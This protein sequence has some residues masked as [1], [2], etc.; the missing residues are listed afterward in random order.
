[1]AAGREY[2]KH[3]QKIIDRYYEHF[4]TIKLT[5]LSEAVTE[6]YLADTP[7]KQERLWKTVATALAKLAKD[8]DRVAKILEEKNVEALAKLVG[9]LSAKK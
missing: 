5:K 8:D 9:E 1:M 2:S 4:D 6:L 3:Q 7:K